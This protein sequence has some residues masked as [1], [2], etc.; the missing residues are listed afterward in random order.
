MLADE[1]QHETDEVKESIEKSVSV[2][3]ENE[4][5]L[6]ESRSHFQSIEK[7]S[8]D[9]YAIAQKVSELLAV[10]VKG[11]QAIAQAI[12]PVSHIAQSNAASAEEVSASTEEQLAAMEELHRTSEDIM[13]IAQ[14]LKKF[15][16]KFVL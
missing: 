12:D 8:R 5:F 14:T 2:S 9:S 11:F 1:I 13:D 7:A 4:S 6:H 16:E 3:R 10:H 15:T